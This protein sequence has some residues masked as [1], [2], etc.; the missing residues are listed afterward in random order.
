MLKP[1]SISKLVKQN[2]TNTLDTV[3]DT[4]YSTDRS[5]C[6]KMIGQPHFETQLMA[7]HHFFS[8]L[9]TSNYGGQSEDDVKDDDS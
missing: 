1:H 8:S 6:S 4:L 3:E 2:K 5:M 9:F 7:C